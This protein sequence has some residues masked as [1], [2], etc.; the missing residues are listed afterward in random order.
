MQTLLRNRGNHDHNLAVVNKKA[1]ELITSRRQH[2]LCYT[3]YSPCPLCL[4]WI[5]HDL[6]MQ[7]LLNMTCIGVKVTP[8]K[9]LE[10]IYV[11]IHAVYKLVYT[12]RATIPDLF[13][14]HQVFEIFN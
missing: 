5:K 2:S 7:M 6:N 8:K 4:E 12:M 14:F 10:C 1:G 11:R 13:L 9:V 3:E